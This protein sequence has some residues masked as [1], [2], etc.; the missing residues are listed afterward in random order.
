M[1]YA[2]SGRTHPRHRAVARAPRNR[3]RPN[4]LMLVCLFFASVLVS[5][6]ASFAVKTPALEIKEVKIKGVRL[7]DRAAVEEAA[8][9]ALGRNILVL[10]KSPIIS[11]IASIHE[12]K[13][14]R[15]G[16]S[17]PNGVWVRV[18]ERKPDAVLTDGRVHFMV[19]RD[20]F[21]FHKTG[22]AIR[23][24]PTLS[25]P[26]CTDLTAGRYARSESVVDALEVL[27]CVRREGLKADKI[28]VDRGGD[29][30]L[31]MGGNF[32]VKIG[33]PDEVA[34]KMSILRSALIYKPS[35]AREAAYIDLTCPSA[36][37]WKPKNVQQ[38]AS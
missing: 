21:V 10:R 19:Q 34:K 7:A 36:P 30:C 26:A 22:G 8:R 24:L 20:G 4:Y 9:S 25:I 29:I 5:G 6:A 1:N 17:F 31:N 38:A 18:W 27:R 14:V 3:A 12:V 37:V 13:S 32:Y 15:M 11:K 2:G 35:I 28:S 33:Q 23:G 16:R